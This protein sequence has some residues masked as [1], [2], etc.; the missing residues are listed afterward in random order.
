MAKQYYNSPE[1]VGGTKTAEFVRDF[2][3]LRAKAEE[4][5]ALIKSTTNDSNNCEYTTK[6]VDP[7]ATGIHWGF[8]TIKE[9]NDSGANFR[10]PL[11]ALTSALLAVGIDDKLADLNIG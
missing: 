9:G 7:P 3:A 11:V 6:S 5:N 2:L 8:W 1:S 10:S 4:L